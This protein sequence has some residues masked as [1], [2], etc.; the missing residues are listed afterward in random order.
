MIKEIARLTEPDMKGLSRKDI[1]AKYE[2]YSKTA[3]CVI[4]FEKVW[5][6]IVRSRKL[7]SYRKS[8]YDLEG[9]MLATSPEGYGNNGFNPL[10]HFFGDDIYVREIMMPKGQ[11]IMSR[12]HKFSHPY[13]ILRGK[14]SILTENGPVKVVAP[15]WGMTHSGTK[16]VLYTHEDTLWITVHRAEEK[17]TNILE[18]ELTAVNFDHIKLEDDADIKS[19]VELIQEEELQCQ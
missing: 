7:K 1:K 5:K 2:L 10:R 13:F 19:F 4:P 3:G 17:D 12:L 11:L 15:Y 18:E 14:V 9:K 16:R 6:G 8:I